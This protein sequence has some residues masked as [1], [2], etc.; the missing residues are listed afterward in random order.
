MAAASWAT[1]S[2]IRAAAAPDGFGATAGD[3]QVTLSW[4]NPNDSSITRYQVLQVAISKLVVPSTA[5]G[6]NAAGDRFGQSVGIDGSRAVVGAPF[7]TS[8]DNSNNDIDDGGWGH[9]FSR[10][11]GGWNYDEFLA[12]SNPQEGGRLGTSVAMAGSTAVIGA[13]SH[14]HPANLDQGRASI[15]AKSGVTGS[16]ATE[17]TVTGQSGNDLFGTSVAVDTGIAVVGAPAAAAGGNAFAGK[18]YLYTKD[19]SGTWGL[20]EIW[21]AGNSNVG[22]D[23]IF[24]T[25]VAVDGNT[26]VVGSPGEDTFAGAVYVF[27]KDNSGWDFD[28][29]LT[30]PG[31][32]NDDSFGRSVAVDDNFVVVGSWGDDDGG[33]QS[34]SVFVFTKPGAGWGAW[35]GLSSS[36]KAALTAKLTASDA[37]MNDRLGWSVAVDG[38]TVLAGAYWEDENGSNS[39]SVY[40]FTKPSVS[41]VNATETVKLTAPDGAAGDFF[42]YSVAAGGGRAIVG[43]PRDDR[44]SDSDIGAAYE[45]SIPA[46][47]DIS[48]SG[49]GTRSHTVTG[50]TNDVEYTFLIRP[51]VGSGYGPASES[52]HATPVQSDRDKPAGLSAQ[53][54]D[55]R[56]TLSWDYPNDSSII[57][58]KYRQKQ[59]GGTF[60][61]WTDISGSGAGT[62]SHTVT[63]LTNGKTYTFRIRA[64]DEAGDS[65]NSNDAS[66]STI[67]TAPANL[68]AAPGDGRVGLTWDDP[69]NDTITKYQ[70]RTDGGT[71]FSDI[72]NSAYGE[73]NYTGYTVTGL[74]NGTTHTFAV[75][76]VNA[77]GDGPAAT[78]TA[79]MVPAAP[80][81]LYATPGDGMAMINWDNPANSTI[82]KY[83]LMQLAEKSALTA[84]DGAAI[85]RFGVS[86]A[87][88]GNTAVVGAFQPTYTDPD[89]SEV[90]SRPGVAY[91]FTRDT[92]TGVWTQKTKL[93][94]ADGA[95]GDGF[96]VSVAVDGDT[97][98]IGA[99]GDDSVGKIDKGAI[100]V[101]RKPAT[102]WPSSTTIATKITATDGE[103]GDLFGASVALYG[104]STIVAGAPRDE[105]EVSGGVVR[106]GSAYVFT[107]SSGSWSPKAKLTASNAAANDEFGNS[108]ALVGDIILVGAY[109]KDG[110]SIT[111]S[112]LVYLFVKP[113]TDDGWTDDTETVRL[114]ASDRAVN[115]NFGRSVALDDA[116][117]VVGASGGTGSA[118]VFTEPS[119]G[120]VA[121]ANSEVTETAK[122]TASDG[123]SG[124]QFG[125]SVAVDGSTI[126][127]GGHQND[128]KGT[129]SGSIYVFTEPTDGWA[130]SREAA[131]LIASDGRAGDRFGIALA[132]DGDTALVAAPRKDANDDD[133]DTGNDV[134][135]AGSAYVIGISDWDAISRSD[136]TTMSHTVSDLTNNVIHTLALRAVNP[137]GYG[138]ASIATVEPI[139]V[140]DA[141]A[142][143]SA[144]PSDGR[145]ALTWD[146]PNDDSIMKYQYSTDYTINGSNVD[147]TFSDISGSDK[148]TT[149]FTVTGLEN[150][151][152]HTLAVRAVNA[153]GEGA[154]ST[155]TV[156]MVPAAPA[157]FLAAPGDERVDLSWDDPSNDTIDYYQL[158][159]LE[160]AKLT[161]FGGSANDAIGSDVA[162]DGDTAVVGAS[163]DS[164]A[165]G[166]A[167]VFARVS[168]AWTKQARLTASDRVAGDLF[169]TSVVL[170]GDTVVVGATRD[171]DKGSG[172]GSV[173]VFT[174]PSGGWDDD[175]Y[176][177]N[178]TAKLLA[179]DGA[180]GDSFGRSVAVDGD[181]V[182]VGAHQ[183]DDKGDDSGSTY[184]F[185][186]PSGGWSAW[187]DLPDNDDDA[188]EDKNRLSAKLL[189]SDGGDGDNYGI[190]VAMDQDTVV[191]GSHG[192]NGVTGK[193][194]V[195]TKPVGGWVNGNEIARLTASD[196][197]GGD[198]FGLSVAIDADTVVVGAI[199]DED[200]GSK[201]GSAYVFTKPVD[202]WDDWDP[203]EDNETA[204]LTASDGVEDDWF[205]FSVAVDGD[206]ILAGAPTDISRRTDF[207]S[208]YLFTRTSGTW[209]ETAKL[210]APDGVTDDRFGW[211]MALDGSTALLG[212]LGASS[213]GVQYSGGA[214]VFDVFGISDWDDIS[215]SDATTI[216]HRVD[217]LTNYQ[218]Y[219]LQVRAVNPSGDGPAS[220]ATA[221]PIPVPDA[222]ANLSAAPSDGRVALTWDDP[223][224]ETITKYEYST[225][226]TINGSNVDATFSDISG[227]DKN[228]TA[229][230]VTGLEN[231]TTHTL[232][233][234]AVNASGEG[235]ASTKTVVMVPAAP[236]NFLAAPGSER[237]DLSWDDPANKTIDK[238]QLLQLE[239]AKLTGF[240]GS[241]NDAIGSDVA[242]DGDTAVVGASGDSDARGAAYVFARVSGAWTI[243]ATL[244]ASDR[245]AGDFFGTAVALSGDTV[246]IGATGDDDKGSGS[247]SV[248]VFTK[249]D[250]G[251]DDWDPTTDNEAAKLTASDGANDDNFGRSVAVSGDTVVVGALYDDDK[252]DDSGSTYV[253][254]KP[255]GG[256]S[257]WN[258]LPD[259]DDD[260]EE[261][262]NRL[263][264]KLLASDGGEGDNYGISVAMDQDTVVVGSHGANGV[265]GKAYVFTKPVGGW[266]NGNETARLTAYDAAEVDQFGISVAI[267]ADTVVVGAIGDDDKGSRSGSVYVFT[268]PS[269]NEGW[270]DWNG[271]DANAK[272]NLTTKLTA[273]DGAEY[274]WFGRTVAVDG[275]IALIG[276]PTDTSRR[277]DFGSAYLFTRTSGTW[278]ETARLNAADAVARDRFGWSAA[279][280]GSTALVG[281]RSA[282]SDGAQY[283]GG[284]YVFDIAD[285]DD[286]SGSGPTTTSHTVTGLAN[287]QEYRFVTRAVNDTGT[288]K[289]SD[290][291]SATP[292]LPKPAKPT[293]LSAEA[294][295]TVVMLGWA[296][297]DDSTI[298]KYQITE[299]IP[300]DFLTATGGAAGAHFGISV[301]IDGD[302]AVVGADRADSKKGSAYIYTRDSNGAW[303][304]QAK[305]DGENTGDQ[306]GWSVAVDG[307]TAIVGAHAYDGEDANGTTLENSGATYVFTKPDTDANG[308]GS[309]DWTDWNSLDDDGR[310]GL[311]A[312]LNPTVPEAFAFF[313]GSV[314]LDGN[315]L[316]IG[317]R[318][319]S[320]G[321]YLSA[322]AAYVFTKSNDGVW[323]QAAKLTASIP[324]QLAYLGYSLAVDGDTVLA[325]AYG[326][327]TVRGEL[328][329]GSAY[330][331]DKPSGGW[332]DG[333]ETAKLTP[334]DRQPSGYFGFSVALDGETAVIGAR[335]HGDPITGAGSGAAYVF[336]RE[337]G[338]WGEKA[339]LTASDTAAGDNFGVSVAVEGDTV[340]VGSWMDE[341]NGRNSGSAYVFEK[342]ALG[343]AGTFETLKLTAPDGAVNDRFGWSVDVDLDAVRGDLALVGSYSDDHDVNGDD[344][345]DLNAGSVH[346]LGIPTWT[347]IAGSG[348]DTTTHTETDLTNGDEYSFQI[349]ALNPSGAGPASDAASATPM[350]KPQKPTWQTRM[351]S[352]RGDTQVRLRWQDPQDSSIIYYQYQ[353]R[354][355]D[356]DF[357]D[358]MGVPDSMA[359]TTEYTV[360]GLE[361]GKQYVFKIQAV[362][363]I[364]AGPPSD[365]LGLRPEDSMPDQPK[366]LRATPGDTQVRLAWNDPGDSSINK[367][368]YQWTG[369]NNTWSWGEDGSSEDWIEVPQGPGRAVA[370]QFTVTGL[371]NEV[372]YTFQIRAVDTVDPLDLE[373]DQFSD[374]SDGATATPEGTPPAAPA[375]LMAKA[376]DMQVELSWNDPD[377]SSIDR[378]RYSIDGVTDSAE[379][380]ADAT[381]HITIGL[382]GGAPLINGTEYTFRV[383]AENESGAGDASTVRAKPLPPEPDPPADLTAAPGNTQVKLTWEDPGDS[384][385]EKYEILHL[386]QTKTLTGEENDNFGFSVA[387][388]GDTAVVGAYRDDQNGD[389]SGAVYVYTRSAGVWDEGVKLIA[390]DG[391]AYDNFGISV[392]VDDDA[393]TVVV[394]ASGDDDGGTDSGSVYVFVKP[395]TD[396]G[397]TDPITEAAKLAAPDG[398]SL[399]YFGISVAVDGDS[400]LV[401]AYQDDDEAS[402]LEDS[403]SAYLFTRPTS[404]GG[405]SD[406][407]GLLGVVKA[408]LTANLTASDRSDDDNFGIFVALDRGTAVI[409]APGDDDA[410]IDSGSVHIFVKPSGGWAD[411]DESVKL[412]APDGE[413][414]DSFG[415]S[416]AVDG[417][418]VVVGAHQDD[419]DGDDSGSTYVFAQPTNSGGWNDW[420]GLSGEDK[421]KLTAKLTAS[422]GEA[423]DS[424]G[425]SVAVDGDSVLVGAYRDDDGVVDSGS[426]YVFSR[427][428]VTG[429]LNETNKLIT[430]NGEA[431]DWFGY[432]V[433]VDTAAHAAL[434]GAGSAHL[435]DIHDWAEIPDSGAE[436][437]DHVVTELTNSQ[438]YDFMVRAV[439]IAGE[440]PAAD[441]SARP[442]VNANID[443]EFDAATT[444]RA[445][446]ED[447]MEGDAVGSPVMADDPDDVL[448]TYSLSGTDTA[449]FDIATTTGQI[450]VGADANFNFE[451]ATTT[452]TVIVSVHDGR[453][454]NGNTD[455]SIDSSITVTIKVTD[456]DED[457][458]VSLMPS[459]ARVNTEII[460]TLTDPDGSESITSWQWATSTDRMMG[461][462]DIPGA[463][464]DRYTPVADDEGHYLQASVT[465]SDRHDVDK[466][467]DVVSS[468][469]LAQ[470]A[471]NSFPSFKDGES[472]TFRVAE[473]T[474][475]PHVVDE[476]TATDVDGDTLTYSVSGLGAAPFVFATST[477]EISVGADANLNFESDTKSYSFTV[478]VHDGKDQF[479]NATTTIDASI[480]VTIY[481]TNV[482]EAGVVSLPTER[483]SVGMELKASLADP[484][485]LD[486]D[487]ISFWRWARA[488]DSN[489]NW[490][491]IAGANAATYYP[492]PADVGKFL[493]AT[494]SYGDGHGSGKS[495]SNYTLQTTANTAPTF[496]DDITLSVDENSEEHVRVGSVTAADV[497]RDTLTY[498]LTDNHEDSFVIDPMSGQI[499]V[500]SEANLN[501]ESPTKSYTVT[502]SVHDGR[503]IDNGF[504]TSIDAE[505]AVTIGVTN[506]EEGGTVDLSL[507]AERQ[508]VGVGLTA[509]VT[510]LDGSVT[511]ISWRWAGAEDSNANWSEIAGANAATYYPVPAD[512]G[513]FLRATASYG[514]GHGSG[515][516]ASNYTL[517]TTANTAP[518]FADD[519][520][521]SVDENSEEHVRVGSVT[522]ADV[523]RDTLTYSLTD[524]HE[525]SF[526]IDP[527]SGQISVGSEANLNFESPT[528]SYTVTVSVHDGRDIDN[529]FST[530]IDAE[531]AVTIGVTNIEEGGT[532]DLSLSAERQSVG[533][534]LTASVTDLDGSVT[535]ISWRWA[536]AEDSNANWSEIAGANAATYY[537][538]P[539][540]VGKF[541]RATASYGDGHGSGKSASNYT[542]QTTANTAPTFADDIT[543][544]VDENSEEHVRVGSV[545]A[546]DVDR[547]TLTYSLTD[548]HE[549]SFVIDPMSGQIS[550]GSEAN[551]N[552]ESPTK[553]Y[554]V[555]V[556]VHDG[557]DIDN[558]FSTSIDAEVAVTINVTDVNERGTVTL[559]IENDLPAPQ[560]NSDLTAILADLD[561]S[562]SNISW[563]WARS[564]DLSTWD[565]IAGADGATYTPVAD[566]VGKFLRARAFYTDGH[567]K[568]KRASEV[569]DDRVLAGAAVS[570]PDRREASPAP[571]PGLAPSTVEAVLAE[572]RARA[573][574][575]GTPTPSPTTGELAPTPPPDIAVGDAAAPRGLLL[576]LG[577]AGLMLVIAGAGAVRNRG[578]S[579]PR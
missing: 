311:T 249:P 329:S 312:K 181:T 223:N 334:S 384:S 267:D 394:G 84:S 483:P 461:W 274:D 467:A 24:G 413:A 192:A 135:D 87:V 55:G 425:Y 244:T 206:V 69:N 395:A 575:R 125:R 569:F 449:S 7:Q 216:S 515:K 251:W 557:R 506:I 316:A 335:Q 516:S 41:W 539:A 13:P 76:A 60:G 51:V 45:F 353:Q 63:G 31:A 252:G 573:E 507:S 163:G 258:A 355:V 357:G 572:A 494:A 579:S 90:V 17:D 119:N 36:A 306:F 35:G 261:D 250:D 400:V 578:L 180:S 230:T 336:A 106:S 304:Q 350:P 100:Y 320:A 225:D 155:K 332:T 544:S 289:A 231:G 290:T 148:N 270:N 156:V 534:G 525:D 309:T 351:A 463:N 504:S 91:V 552:F 107:R 136:A 149:A 406:W 359:A 422:D 401:G 475:A 161:G 489:A 141:P 308:D 558:G 83:Q 28:A 429:K 415:H 92:N 275:N 431:G 68:T 486:A 300:E 464:T 198:Q 562:I 52:K 208:A 173:Y 22:V 86:V 481:V 259:N 118:Y 146:N 263:S 548:N 113:D 333:N 242:I 364:G 239:L 485:R 171:D 556:S 122:L 142:N 234:R 402:D 458:T 160:L 207:G 53:G 298:D 371:T 330:V 521:L 376:G 179:S 58:Y 27:T 570:A 496:A 247:G 366:G 382:T 302:T 443:P 491:E 103:G 468:R 3:T 248:Y 209:S 317:S 266:V 42:G 111:D 529:G 466:S 452:Y 551:L 554:T 379:I 32:A 339:R 172:S 342:P 442:E 129:D 574:S 19:S 233:V 77:T 178:E 527:M 67:P 343:W 269:S 390:P 271:L 34:G 499:S 291:V 130:D 188:E 391:A 517:Q 143:L 462:N 131:K 447:A 140:P 78:V 495:A 243:Q 278:G 201:S 123:A 550:V 325:G 153:S 50:L 190:S 260:A 362:N 361:N 23:H 434:V 157:N 237:V 4:N 438:T 380:S 566:D 377:D 444:T 407:A 265:R 518:T 59:S 228:T 501:F 410:G 202:G 94:A 482:D 177:G 565:T 205:G 29:R 437:T 490:S 310:A 433:A 327:D 62:T 197:G 535:N 217:E 363:D 530:S 500:G 273:S 445:V 238:Y 352:D 487:S 10:G 543:L 6:A 440:G 338:V 354:E 293:D 212:A 30:A 61:A 360:T 514:D 416:V 15:V 337:S 218:E 97:V 511:N 345:I 158:L 138:V 563:E 174:K 446:A 533:V 121:N 96:G 549:D 427:D 16:W 538:V 116:T 344:I 326:D 98:V 14:A 477:G 508:S 313:G 139:P 99:R 64:V 389:D 276:A 536:G 44:D 66:A 421:A 492:V 476:V 115:D 185:T 9:A 479:D 57:K 285:W 423:G 26:V 283:A 324:R 472:V 577:L 397:W 80:A 520:T 75:R 356:D 145:V 286:I 457:G 284:A 232:A 49:A 480:Q 519:I 282:S 531:V 287:Y 255:S 71:T 214:Y 134:A 38:G 95:A 296:D 381:M 240:G 167:Y 455:T 109:G 568:D 88:D 318:R 398:E 2:S 459:A 124:D 370:H 56:V 451:S 412:T 166:A 315:T 524:N 126:L 65:D 393:N 428:S 194:Y 322:G 5:P 470:H 435:L 43:A 375:N 392:A 418:T 365:E 47:S 8:R 268:K 164:S 245:V 419:D 73:A 368:E 385:I 374:E 117:I 403:G 219:W 184:V 387:L 509:S 537:P 378:Y 299:V 409:G 559:S 323:S 383:W 195:F 373:D 555:T 340:V 128:E 474:S 70:Y 405:W 484:D 503:D 460:A 441:K 105:I 262:K 541:L 264:A 388:D 471:E 101:F 120:W 89:T 213:D 348:S 295:D 168:G 328:G 498:S 241:A 110:N 512:V 25:S 108:V 72:P 469:V 510:D 187:N 48:G 281:A 528:K 454:S 193:T 210:N 176:N 12:V 546:A 227:S 215:G 347:D 547:D 396:G 417:D 297:P 256:W 162:I 33:S 564:D 369:D 497:D 453:D 152:T 523:D 279:L 203:A 222:P 448:L 303:T 292:R 288:G 199:G 420:A 21:F 196:G 18:A 513:K 301:A 314:A 439:N 165:R 414:G 220:T 305:F 408:R 553:S 253:F 104:D 204:K 235:A 488:E 236:A 505:V 386:L 404:A 127:V 102:G 561:G 277:T 526:V 571:T 331:F 37:A 367:Y 307:D 424:F 175:D 200:K 319:Y 137:S 132:L 39:G 576:V 11:S 224:N 186:K 280:D 560:A 85:D 542:L 211:S 341:D 545:T 221:T 183:D 456:V 159:Q 170:S 436:T 349:R 399:D 567:G 133:D 93:T 502:V 257:T 82:T 79:L 229:F 358:W 411:A 147:A 144:A 246:V 532:V 169:G 112:G 272:A 226:Y 40:L 478:S 432:S 182:V 191:V 189:A 426:A 154:A 321:G 1:I 20:T 430:P 493:R 372:E 74:V 151:T 540:D 473:N 114:R 522:A 46:W 54:G 346:V 450:T 254:T 81:N 465:Y 150:G 294:G